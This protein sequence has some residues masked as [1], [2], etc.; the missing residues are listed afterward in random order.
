MAPSK[1][2][3]IPVFS[4]NYIWMIYAG[5]DAIVVDPGDAHPVIHHLQKRK[6]QLKAILLTHQHLDHIGG[7]TKLLNT[8]NCQVFAPNCSAMCFP[9][10]PTFAGMTIHF[11][12]RTYHVI[13]TPGH[14]VEHVSYFATHHDKQ[15]WLFCAD[16]LFSIG[17]GRIFNSLGG[18]ASD[19]Y[20]SL[21]RI[22]TLPKDTLVFPA[23]EYTLDNI[24]FAL[25]LNPDNI[26]LQRYHMYCEKQRG[27]N[28]PT[29]PVRLA[30]EVALNPFLSV[31]DEIAFVK[32]RQ[33]K[34]LFTH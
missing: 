34:D 10:T 24:R 6:L 5:S 12:D 25:S 22:K 3:P 9:F 14:T 23:H 16:T 29:L 15:P 27:Q 33:Q 4:S 31:S 13:K 8:Y 28:L 32:L 11:F 2:Y 1:V 19:L 30:D 21:Q 7:V 26:K 20:Q 18:N 17:C